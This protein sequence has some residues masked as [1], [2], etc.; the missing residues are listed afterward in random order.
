MGSAA[1]KFIHQ[2]IGIP[3]SHLV[4]PRLRSLSQ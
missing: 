4:G 3:Q 2:P 1:D